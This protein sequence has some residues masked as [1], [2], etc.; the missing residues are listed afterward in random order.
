[1]YNCWNCPLN[2]IILPGQD[3]IV[4]TGGP[5]TEKRERERKKQALENNLNTSSKTWSRTCVSYSNLWFVQQSIPRKCSAQQKKCTCNAVSWMMTLINHLSMVQNKLIR[6]AAKGVCGKPVMINRLLDNGSCFALG[7]EVMSRR[8]Y[9][10]EDK[11]ARERVGAS[12][13]TVSQ[14]SPGSLSDLIE[15]LWCWAS[16]A[17]STLCFSYLVEPKTTVMIKELLSFLV[18]LVLME[19][20]C[21][22]KKRKRL[23]AL[24]NHP[25]LYKVNWLFCH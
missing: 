13:Q 12:W 17:R 9:E 5:A 23:R 2:N 20:S 16:A 11:Q 4:L 8:V 3:E 22:K 24:I 1:M 7:H 15:M 18:V 25:N 14:I 21:N 10:M 6:A 19:Y